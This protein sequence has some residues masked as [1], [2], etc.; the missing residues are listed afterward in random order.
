MARE[1]GGIGVILATYDQ[2]AYLELALLAYSRQ[3]RCPD[4]IVVA[5]DGSGSETAEVVEA[6]ARRTGLPLTHVR[7]PDRGFRKTT[8][9]N[10]AIRASVSPYLVFSDGDCLPG[11]RF[12]ET[13]ARLRRPGRYLAGSA[14]RLGSTVSAAVSPEIVLDGSYATLSWLRRMGARPRRRVLRFAPRPLGALM[15]VLTPTRP[16]WSGG[17]AS[18]A[19]KEILRVNGFDLELEYGGEDRVF[20]ERLRNAGVKGIQIRHRALVLHLDHARP[21]R[22]P[23]RVQ[24]QTRYRKAIQRSRVV[25]AEKG[26][27]ELPE[28]EG[29]TIRRLGLE[30][31][32]S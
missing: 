21:Y 7:H 5:D 26:L 4:E 9:L 16:T 1:G 30:K 29:V 22:D 32:V 2:P 11:P 25:E 6:M 12:V 3:S 24:R 10:R 18:V 31:E 23:E 20:G 14:V 27:A 15:D 17:N 19:R 13:H 8:I 28:E